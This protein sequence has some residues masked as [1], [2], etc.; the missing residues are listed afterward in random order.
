VSARDPV[1]NPFGLTANLNAYVPR[2][3]TE[4]AL[5]ALVRAARAGRRPAALIGP[6]GIGKTLLLHLLADRVGHELRFV[7]LPYGTLPPAELCA[8]A[9]GRLL[10]AQSR[11]PCAALLEHAAQ[12][13]RQGSALLLLL[14][15]VGGMPLESARWL[16][17]S[18]AESDGSL[19]LVAA[20]ADEPFT[21]RVLEALS[22]ELE[23]VRFEAAMSEAETRE[24]VRTRLELGGANAALC[25]RFDR[26]TLAML[27][28]LSE[29]IP[30]QVHALASAVIRGVSTDLV[31]RFFEEGSEAAAEAPPVGARSARAA[32]AAG[33]RAVAALELVEGVRLPAVLLREAETAA[34][35]AA[36]LPAV[37]VAAVPPSALRV[38]ATTFWAVLALAG[39]VAL[40]PSPPDPPTRDPAR[41]RAGDARETRAARVADAVPARPSR[42]QRRAA[43]PLQ[44]QVNAIP[45]ALVEVDGVDMGMTPRAGIPLLPGP[46]RFRARMPDGRVLE[47]TI[48]IGLR[49]R[50]IVFE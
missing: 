2:R 5:S 40:R 18:V 35:N 28:R 14:D 11:D 16:G 12:L 32:E 41:E 13:G 1:R 17:R 46:H 10:L 50:H 23:V 37:R 42:E 30:S 47:R 21:A 31:E 20:A 6:R 22:P 25:A 39:L 24:Y 7:Y 19:R 48:E 33:G 27:Q 4:V 34:S 44:V 3:A 9:L 36:P 43:E 8:W 49:N 29:G 15:E 38:F 45:W 26:E